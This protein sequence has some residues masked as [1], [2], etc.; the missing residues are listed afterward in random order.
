MTLLNEFF[1]MIDELVD[2]YDLEKIKTI[3]DC[4]IPILISNSSSFFEHCKDMVAGGLP[5]AKP[6]HLE[7]VAD[8]AI[9]LLQSVREFNSSEQYNIQVRVGM[10]CGPVVAGVI[11]RSKFTYLRLLSSFRVFIKIFFNNHKI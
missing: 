3:G 8:F 1:S 9:E 6:D 5:L 7:R 10:H 4:C 11:G 2:S